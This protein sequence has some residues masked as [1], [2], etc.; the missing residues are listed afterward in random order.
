MVWRKSI[1]KEIIKVV[2]EKL[3]KNLEDLKQLPEANLKQP[4]YA[5]A[6]TILAL[7]LWRENKDEAI[8]MINYLKGPDSLSVYDINFISERLKNKE[9]TILSYFLGSNPEN[10]YQ[11]TLPYTVLISE[12]A[13]SRDEEGYIKFYVQSSGADSLRPI[14]VRQKPSSGQ[15]YLWEQMLLS[16]VR[17]PVKDDDWA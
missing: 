5:A 4:H 2:F 9:Y 1:E 6:L 10:G 12:L 14:Q 8:K 11:P 16:E 15:W 3:P 13:H 7:N 17:P